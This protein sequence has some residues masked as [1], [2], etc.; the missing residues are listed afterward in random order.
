MNRRLILRQLITDRMGRMRSKTYLCVIQSMI[1]GTNTLDDWT[2][3]ECD[4][5][6]SRQAFLLITVV[7]LR[8][9][10]AKRLIPFLSSWPS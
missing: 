3:R 8:K 10:W 7:D 5:S 9:H 6:V 1:I 4:K 2:I